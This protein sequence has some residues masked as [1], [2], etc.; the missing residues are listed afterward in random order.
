M[1][2]KFIIS[3]FLAL[4]SFTVSAENTD[5]R[6]NDKAFMIALNQVDGKQTL[7]A[8]KAD[9]NEILNDLNGEKTQN[10]TVKPQSDNSD[11][12]GWL[13]ALALFGFV[14]L[15]NRRGV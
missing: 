13:L 11:E 15:S 9:S 5:T 3:L 12:T 4:I 2:K 14:M 10:N 7:L 8:S 1:F 6:S